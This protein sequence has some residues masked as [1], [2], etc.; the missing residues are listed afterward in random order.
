MRKGLMILRKKKDYQRRILARKVAGEEKILT[1][2]DIY[3]GSM[4]LRGELKRWL[5]KRRKRNVNRMRL[6]SADGS[7]IHSSSRHGSASREE[8]A[9]EFGISASILESQ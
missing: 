9:Q 7:R 4:R 8:L 3:R 1:S 2:F 6:P 5:L